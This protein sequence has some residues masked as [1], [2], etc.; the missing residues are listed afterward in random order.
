[1]HWKVSIG[2]LLGAGLAIAAPEPQDTLRFESSVFMISVPVAV[3]DG[4]DN[5]I[6]DLEASDFTLYEDGVEQEISLFARGLEESWVGM[7]PALKEASSGNQVMGLILDASGS[8]EDQ[9]DLVHSAVLKFLNNIPRTRHLV[10]LDFD[11]NMRISEY[12]SDDQRQIAERIYEIEAE[13]WTALYDAVAT[14]LE[15]VYYDDGRKTL[16]VF[17]DGV[18]SR[19]T[20]SMGES[21]DIVRASD[22]T[23]HTIQFGGNRSNPLRDFEQGRFL[24]TISKLTGGSYAVASSLEDLDEF[25][26]RILDE[27]FSQY[28]LGYVSANT[29]MD[30]EYRRIE[31]EVKR[32]DIRDIEVRAREG[33]TAPLLE[34]LPSEEE[35]E[36]EAEVSRSKP[37]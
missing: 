4:D 36:V 5:F 12:S 18:D 11:E 27:L 33:Y 3:T 24:R 14:V 26:D 32:D 10:V 1:M 29:A 9:M 7:E 6:K 22:V 28:M 8:M 34:P 20:L 15:R 30:G 23:I 13:G 37:E 2:V 21:F 16:V 19:S 25:Y 31:V 35:D 17:S